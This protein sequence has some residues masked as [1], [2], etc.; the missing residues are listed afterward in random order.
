VSNTTEL[1]EL[2]DELAAWLESGRRIMTRLEN[3]QV[4]SA[5][6]THA[7]REPA[8]EVEAR[9]RNLEREL[10]EIRAADRRES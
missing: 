7:T 9:F 1:A 2:R 3:L 4:V 8:A 10:A 6:E 5:A